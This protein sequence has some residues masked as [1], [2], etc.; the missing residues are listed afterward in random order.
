M[1]VTAGRFVVKGVE[2]G[3]ELERA[4][5]EGAAARPALGAGD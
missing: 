4:D 2:E 5:E 1:E 3:E